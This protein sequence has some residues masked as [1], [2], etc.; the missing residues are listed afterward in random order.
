MGSRQMT[1]ASGPTQTLIDDGM[2][3]GEL[4]EVVF[5]ESLVLPV[6][7]IT[8]GGCDIVAQSSLDFGMENQT[9]RPRSAQFQ[10]L[11]DQQ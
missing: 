4:V 6:V 2:Q 9:E 11:C 8:K 1:E 3:V 10:S 5:G 7:L